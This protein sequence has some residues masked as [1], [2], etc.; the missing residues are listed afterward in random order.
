MEKHS[1]RRRQ[2]VAQQ[3]AASDQSEWAAE[4][5]EAPAA[6][7]AAGPAPGA[8]PQPQDDWVAEPIADAAFD[9]KPDYANGLSPEAPINKSP[10]D[11]MD[12]A[13]MSFGNAAGN[14]QFLKSKFQAVAKD[15]DGNF[16]VQKDGLWYR[17]DAKNLE[18]ADAWKVTKSFLKAGMGLAQPGLFLEDAVKDQDSREVLGDYAD[19]SKEV[20]A[21]SLG[22]ATGGAATAS[23]G[24]LG[25]AAATGAGIATVNT[26]LGRAAGT[27][28]AS[29]EQQVKDIAF[30][31]AFNVMGVGI[32]L[33]VKPTG[34]WIAKRLPRVAAAYKSM[35]DAGKSVVKNTWG[36]M[37]VGA[38]RWD[39]LEQHA[40][41]M[42]EAMTRYSKTANDETFEQ[43]AQLDSMKQIERLSKIAPKIES[44]MYGKMSAD[45]VRSV[46]DSFKAPIREVAKDVYEEAAAAGLGVFEVP[47]ARATGSEFRK[48][49][50]EGGEAAVERSTRKL[51]SPQESLELLKSGKLPKGARFVLRSQKE[52]LSDLHATGQFGEFGDLA[53]DA[54][55][56]NQIT[57]AFE[58]IGKLSQSKV[59]TG[60]QGAKE[61]LNL[62][63]I[64]SRITYSLK[65]RGE[66]AGSALTQSFAARLNERLKGRFA[67]TFD[68]V[69]PK[70]SDGRS[71]YTALNEEYTAS[72]KALDTLVKATKNKDNTKGTESF[73]NRIFAD[74]K[75]NVTEKEALRQLAE[76]AKRHGLPELGVINEAR[77][78]LK[79][80][81]AVIA[82]NPMVKPGLLGKGS[83]TM[84]AGSLGGA[85]LGMG[86]G[87][88]AAA[89]AVILGGAVTSPRVAYTLMQGKNYVSALK[90]EQLEMLRQNPE[91]LQGL[92]QTTLQVP[93]IEEGVKQKLLQGGGT[94]P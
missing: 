11:L 3:Q 23:M 9:L 32:P 16:I 72:K 53:T 94:P 46:D 78:R 77:K 29:V 71:L 92:V 33:G 1:T 25:G 38:E 45:I 70:T 40:D 81:D 41:E 68:A 7:A 75:R 58:Q 76:T 85:A 44:K 43:L 20:G 60:K 30:E 39:V 50:L 31:T 91:L 69:T 87:L 57:D 47:A 5:F 19:L 13:K 80:N 86:G 24:L 12:R 18:D 63:K 28:E 64:T 54:T 4:P 52:L 15:P 61:L 21:V 37:T 55:A 34:A 88:P 65:E 48:L 79:I 6:P 83:Q 17:A 66:N 22:I 36:R 51:L 59:T 14:E 10:V 49:F 56:Y 67:E 90:A 26:S 93:Q 82:F 35:T 27:Y 74:N 42:A 2:Q 62:Q 89:G 84:F 73:V 8:A